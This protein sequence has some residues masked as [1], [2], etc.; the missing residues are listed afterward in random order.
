MLKASC[1]SAQA[2]ALD[3]VFF[4]LDAEKLMQFRELLDAPNSRNAGLERLLAV[5]APWIA[6]K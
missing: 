2:V 5:T 4:C 6:G 1:D 3:Q